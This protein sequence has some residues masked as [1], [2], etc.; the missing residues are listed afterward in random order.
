MFCITRH[1]SRILQKGGRCDE[2]IIQS[3]RSALRPQSPFE[4]RGLFSHLSRD[5]KMN[6][7]LDQLSGHRLFRRPHARIHLGDHDGGTA[8]TCRRFE[9]A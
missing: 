3:D 9:L 6:E 5:G 8:V 2:T 4:L 7:P 1:E